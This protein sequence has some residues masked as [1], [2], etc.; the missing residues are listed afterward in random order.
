MAMYY[1]RIT[2]AFLIRPPLFNHEPFK[3]NC[4]DTNE[5]IK[6]FK[7]E[8]SKRGKA[9]RE[10]CYPLPFPR[11]HKRRQSLSIR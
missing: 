10:N 5:I 7:H 6:L 11:K 2:I 3:I 1:Y 9:W 4:M 8:N